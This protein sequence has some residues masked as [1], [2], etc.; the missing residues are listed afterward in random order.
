MKTH[1][2]TLFVTTQGAYLTNDGQAVA[3]R[4]EKET[5]L[6]VPVHNLD[7]IVC[8]G[9]IGCSPNLMGMCGEAGV[10]IVAQNLW[11]WREM[12]EHGVSGFLGND[13][14]EL[15]HY[16]AMLTHDE[17]LRQ[18]IIRAAY[19]RLLHELAN[20]EVIWDRWKRLFHSLRGCTKEVH[21][22]DAHWDGVVPTTVEEAA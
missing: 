4:V 12:I 1:L 17:E 2:Y 14:C 21:S 19:D 6:R 16:T 13:D 11:G 5:R 22:G 10:P 15:A 3:V 20:P 7:G 8:F 9:R 18:R